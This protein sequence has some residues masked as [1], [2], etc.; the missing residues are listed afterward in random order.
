MS[1]RESEGGGGGMG[2]CGREGVCACERE[3]VC[4]GVREIEG[5]CV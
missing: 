5:E 4:G 3:R 2:L 1:P